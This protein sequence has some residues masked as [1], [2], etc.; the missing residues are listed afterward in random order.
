M[1][2]NK[3]LGHIEK[4]DAKVATAMDFNAAFGDYTG[5]DYNRGGTSYPYLLIMQSDKQFDNFID[6]EKMTKETY[7][8]LFVRSQDKN[9]IS[10]LKNTF[11]GIV[12]KEQQGAELWKDNKCLFTAN[13]FVN[14]EMKQ[15]LSMKHGVD[16]KEVKNVIKLLVKLTPKNKLFNGEENEFAMITIKGASFMPYNE[17]VKEKQQELFVKSEQMKAM[18]IPNVSKVPV[19]FWTLDISSKPVTEKGRTYYVFDFKV[20]ETPAEVAFGLKDAMKEAGNFDLISM[21]AIGAAS[22]Q[23]EQPQERYQAEAPADYT[24]VESDGEVVD[25][26]EATLVDP[27]SLP[28]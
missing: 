12:I 4:P 22:A 2:N 8:K 1:S 27:D 16:V 18:G 9:H 26:S 23:E 3:Q 10:D 5:S 13:H 11:Q 17:Q 7:G 25:A 14:A 19:V 20:S 21:R 28:F 6:G 24:P 15:E